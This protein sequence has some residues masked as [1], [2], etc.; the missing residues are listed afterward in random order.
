M[1]NLLIK[2]FL[3]NRNED[4]RNTVTLQEAMHAY[5]TIFDVAGTPMVVVDEDHTILFTNQEME[6]FSKTNRQDIE[7]KE[8]FYRFIHP[9]HLQRLLTYHTQRRINTTV[10]PPESYSFTFIDAQGTESD[11]MIKARLIPD[12]KLSVISLA[13]LSDVT[14]LENQLHESREKYRQLFENAQE[15]I[16][17]ST[18][19]GKILLAN[20]AFVHM[21][22]YNSLDEVL[23]LNLARDI[24]LNNTQR[25]DTLTMFKEKDYYKNVELY[26]KKRDGTPLIIRA[27]GHIT[28]DSNNKIVNYETTVVDIT[29]FKKAQERLE[30]SRQYFKNIIDCLPDPTFTI[31]TESK[32]TA[33]NKAMERLTG[34]TCEHMLGR[35]DYEYA[36]PLYGQRQ[37]ILIDF[38]LDPSLIPVNQYVYVRKEGDTLVA[39]AYAPALYSGKGGFVWG[40]AS[41]IRD[42]EGKVIG[43]I[44]TIKDFTEYKETQEK[45]RFYTMHDILTG[46][47]NRIY[48]EEELSRL[49]N[50]RF[51]PISVIMVDVDGL[52]LINDSMG[53]PKGDELLKATGE[54]LRSAFRTSDAISRIGGDEFAVILPNTNSKQAEAAAKRIEDTLH[55][56]N[57]TNIDFPL[58]LSI[59]FATGKVPI[60]EIIIEADNNL[61][62]N[63]LHRSSSAKSHFTA[64]LMAMLAERDYVTEGHAD[65]LEKLAIVMAD[66]LSLSSKE[67][68]DLILLAK[69]HDIGKVG[70]SDNLL[71]KKGPLTKKEMEEMKRHSE[72]GYRIAQ[73][74]P[75]LGHIANYILHHHEWWNGEGYPLGLKEND[76]PLACRIISILDTYDAMT[77]DRPY[78]KSLR[79]QTVINHITKVK[80]SQFDPRLV[81]LFLKILRK[82]NY[83]KPEINN[84]A[85]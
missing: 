65:R 61:N 64:T 11:V 70:I 45:L 17:Q 12:T 37:P 19:D 36:I 22:G 51:T 54:I 72:I 10:T 28:R 39:E 18:P 2:A 4:T 29:D 26:W 27:S 83:F 20:A 84:Q 24:Y 60:Q 69:F 71:L 59:G 78:R 44:N 57:T 68:T 32:V 6:Q 49:D 53:H 34:L 7:G 23:T 58:S 30:A 85:Q 74:S 80:G 43:A 38:V 79:Y 5:L 33:W 75:E 13:K 3:L 46:H 14:T 47:Y 42:G 15:G 63:K 21:L 48:F 56:Y 62:R 31:D 1:D 77:S 35:D 81:D 8:K 73:S 66:E 76:I 41:I 40:S 55:A 82:H 9:A 25:N 67:K 50:S 16:Y 52:K